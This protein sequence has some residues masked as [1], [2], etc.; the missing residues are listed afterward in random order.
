[1]GHNDLHV[2]LSHFMSH[3]INYLRY[4]ISL[5]NSLRVIRHNQWSMKYKSH[6]PTYILRSLFVSHGT[7]IQ[8][9]TFLYQITF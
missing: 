3:G 2:F 1:M 5:S 4:D 8:G 7:S 9:M 6:L